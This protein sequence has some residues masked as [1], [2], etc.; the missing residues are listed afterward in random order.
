MYS[1]I[2]NHM[3]ALPS[4]ASMSGEGT[5]TV[6]KPTATDAATRRLIHKL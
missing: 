6:S 1:I 3:G 2:S 5:Y 4:S